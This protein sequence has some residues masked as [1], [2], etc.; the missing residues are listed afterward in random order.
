VSEVS[1]FHRLAPRLREAIVH[2]LGWMS[3]RPVQELAGEA[4][5]GGANAVVLAPT[6]GGKTEAS[7]FPALHELIERPPRGV[8]VVYV[9][10]IKALLNNQAER[11]GLYTEMVGLRRFVWHGDTPPR[12]KRAFL[13][14]PAEL[15]MTTPESLEVM[16]ASS[17][18]SERALFADLRMLVVDEVHAL[19]GTDRGAHLMCVMERLARLCPHDVQRVGLSATV[20]NPAE[21]LTW[22]SG[23]SRRAGVVVDPPKNPAPRH[24]EVRFAEDSMDIAAD[25][26]R[27]A[28]GQKSLVFCEGRSVT[29]DIAT[30]M[31]GSGI[32]VFV[33]HSSVALEARRNAEER[34]A[35]G[36]NTAILCTS[37]LELGIDVGDLDR[38]FQVEAPSSVG[39]FLQRMG[40][41]G[42]RAGSVAN[43]TFLCTDTDTVLQAAALVELARR[44]WVENVTVDQRCWPV[45]VH[46]LLALTLAQGAVTPTE[47]WETLKGVP[48]FA[49]I[50]HDEFD[51]IV[52]H[53]VSEDFLF[54]DAGRLAMGDKAEKVYGRKNFME[55]YAVFSSPQPYLVVTLQGRELGSLEQT[56]V[57]TLSE[58][59]SAFLLAGKAWIAQHVNH[60][61]RRVLVEAAPRGKKP[62]WTSFVPQ[63]LGP[64]VC[65]AIREVLI[66]DAPLPFVTGDAAVRLGARRGELGV[67]L[68]DGA[69]ALL[70]PGELTWW[71]FAGGKVNLTL[72]HALQ[73]RSNWE[74]SSDNLR[75][76]VRGDSVLPGEWRRHLVELS[77]RATWE[78]LLPQIRAGLPEYR[79]SK[80]QRALPD[81]AQREM[82]ERFL[83]DVEGARRTAAGGGDVV[84]VEATIER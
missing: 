19:A 36:R 66:S 27:L 78:A 42:R 8:G 57:D 43:T 11:L 1:V 74:V 79:L 80:F 14:D 70:V 73:A 20:G 44:G 30:R 47:A 81:W 4:L 59:R 51:E 60:K 31:R 17:R 18:V 68:R 76:R 23:S 75:I 28:G 82:V 34:F 56:F 58:G 7:M 65:A 84:P 50:A 52:D 64:E 54:F 37:T 22:I 35:R 24:I 46:Q 67:L 26:T 3:L 53:M 39:S 9:A 38:V 10:P 12:E 21:I 48:D 69:D 63:F 72:R 25:I 61:D 32:D 71:T 16:L 49:G 62:S 45:L 55:L 15:L 40:R 83:L 33:H 5:L 2:R 41:T 29:E 6:A 77:D 13:K